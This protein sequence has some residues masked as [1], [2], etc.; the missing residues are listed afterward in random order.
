MFAPP[1][2][3]DKE[4]VK[5]NEQKRLSALKPLVEL[6]HEKSYDVLR[7]SRKMPYLTRDHTLLAYFHVS[8]GSALADAGTYIEYTY[9]VRATTSPPKELS[10]MFYHYENRG[11]INWES[12]EEKELDLMNIGKAAKT[13]DS[14]YLSMALLLQKFKPI[15]TK[16]KK[17]TPVT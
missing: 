13:F 14:D 16:Q 9:M 4:L 15:I 5:S 7:G 12:R 2:H 10:T 11:K 17:R 6:L 3:I 1:W 8:F